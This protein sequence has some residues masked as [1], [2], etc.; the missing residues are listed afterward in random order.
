MSVSGRST[1][2]K[3]RCSGSANDVA[4]YCMRTVRSAAPQAH[5]GN[6]AGAGRRRKRHRARTAT[7][8]AAASTAAAITPGAIDPDIAGSRTTAPRPVN[9][10]A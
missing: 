9:L 8:N 2:P 5:S 4:V 3:T 10:T 1:S 6:L 7:A